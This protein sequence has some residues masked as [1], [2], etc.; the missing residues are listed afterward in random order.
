MFA[1]RE[2]PIV[3]KTKHL[4]PNLPV[5][6]RALFGNSAYLTSKPPGQADRATGAMKPGDGLLWL[7]WLRQL[8]LIEVEGQ[9]ASK[10]LDQTGAF[11]K[12]K[13]DAA[14]LALQLKEIFVQFKEVLT[15]SIPKMME[16]VIIE[17]IIEQTFK[18]H[19]MNGILRPHG[20]VLSGHSGNREKLKRD[21]E[22]ELRS[23]FVG[24][25]HYILS[26]ARMFCGHLSSYILLEQYCSE[27]CEHILRVA[28]S[29]LVPVE[30]TSEE[31]APG[32]KPQATL[33]TSD[34]LF[35]G[36]PAKFWTCLWR[37]SPSSSP[38]N[39]RLRIQIDDHNYHDFTP[40]WEHP[41]SEFMVYAP[42]GI[43]Q[44]PS[45]AAKEVFG[46]L[47]PEGFIYSASKLGTFVDI[48]QTPPLKIANYKDIERYMRK[49]GEK[50]GHLPKL[51]EG[52]S[53]ITEERDYFEV[54]TTTK[55]IRIQDNIV[56]RPELWRTW[57][58]RENRIMT[59]DEFK[60][61]SKFKK[62][63]VA[64][65]R[66]FLTRN[67]I[68]TPTRFGDAFELKGDVIPHIRR[69]LENPSEH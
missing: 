35:K 32:A 40:F 64:G 8:W 47:I 63:A 23:R 10:F 56:N 46:E 34:S 52:V 39:V 59:V 54:L 44:K 31:E 30:F 33:P 24:D 42:S 1:I 2:L 38:K 61:Y 60:K 13:V 5:L 57:I 49:K 41:G 45:N 53:D 27:G 62:K 36:R 58:D 37:L 15:R 17:S 26:T 16:E 51:R 19:V 14:K 12:R 11:A 7:P 18:N 25:K 3:E 65:F 43:P 4:M 29:L 67:G 66:H 55:L 28:R 9:E 6:A 68:A 48:S 20:W 22:K 21:Y 69:L 50:V